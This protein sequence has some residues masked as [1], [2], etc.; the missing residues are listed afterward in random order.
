MGDR[1]AEL[2][3]MKPDERLVGAADILRIIGDEMRIELGADFN[4]ELIAAAVAP[5]WLEL[6]LGFEL[7][8]GL[9]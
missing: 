3:L 9:R 4:P 8:V 6:L 5:V 2:R 7:T 1:S